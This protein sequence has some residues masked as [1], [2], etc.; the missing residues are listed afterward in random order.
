[1]NNTGSCNRKGLA[2]L[3]YIFVLL[4]LLWAFVS[5]SFYIRQAYM[6]QMHKAGETFASGRQ[7]G[8]SRTHEC[9][10]EAEVHYMSNATPPVDVVQKN[11]IY[12]QACYDHLVK[13]R[14]CAEQADSTTCFNYAK[15]SCNQQYA[16]SS[17]SS[18]PPP[19]TPVCGDGSCTGTE[20]CLSCPTDCVAAC[21]QNCPNNFCD[22]GESCVTCS[23]DC[24]PC[25][26]NGTCGAG[27]NCVSCPAD[28]GPCCPNG[29]CGAGEN[30]TLCPADCGACPV[31]CPN[32]TCDAGEDCTCSDCACAAPQVCFNKACCTPDCSGAATCEDDGCGN[33]CGWCSPPALC[34]NGSCCTPD[35]TGTPCGDDTC[36]DPM[37]CGSC[38]LPE[39]CDQ[40]GQCVVSPCTGATPDP[41]NSSLCNFNANGQP[42]SCVAVCDSVTGCTFQCQAGFHCAGAACVP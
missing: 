33:P 41:S 1:M 19:P 11:V 4:V 29:S 17:L 5:F 30:C 16:C 32:G 15:V 22:P 40:F 20:D 23:A 8:L 31:G 3:E 14:N 18:N 36:G 27:E 24:G 35:C 7:Y 21:P 10:Y 28:C 38:V 37:G 26:G 6:G 34:Y 12:S 42:F 9:V 39:V 13:V 25:C 2:Y